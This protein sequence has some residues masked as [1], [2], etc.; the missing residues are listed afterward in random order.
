MGHWK[1]CEVNLQFLA[2]EGEHRL[3]RRIQRALLDNIYANGRNGGQIETES[4]VCYICLQKPRMG[5]SP[6]LITLRN[7][8]RRVGES[9]GGGGG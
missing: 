6:A 4:S 5:P 3:S 7:Y 9:G 8:Q 1:S 2:E